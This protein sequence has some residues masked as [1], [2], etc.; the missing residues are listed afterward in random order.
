[1][2]KLR[3]TNIEP[4]S[5]TTLTLGAS[6]DAA[7]ISSD[8]LKANTWQDVGGNN[9][10]VSNGSGTLSN[11]A[12]ALA[13]G[14]M[15]LISTTTLNNVGFANIGGMSSAYDEY[16]WV[17]QNMH[18]DSNDT[19][20]RF[21]TTSDNFSS[22]GQNILTAGLYTSNYQSTSNTSWGT[23]GVYSVYDTT[24]HQQIME[25]MSNAS[26][27]GGSGILKIYNPGSTVYSKQWTFESSFRRHNPAY[28]EILIGGH[29]N[30]ATAVDGIRFYMSSG[31]FDGTI[32]LYGVA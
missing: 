5:G 30:V 24:D 7:L 26:E 31:N 15:T 32:D 25:G 6:G 13:G 28:N 1:M 21:K 29:I 2:S 3:A 11:V 12:G 8:S 19:I 18:A 17:F 27:S 14:G 4:N 20:L 10:W 16:W 22:W 9:Y 23:S